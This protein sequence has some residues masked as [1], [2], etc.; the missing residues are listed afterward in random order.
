MHTL[1]LTL[2]IAPSSGSL[3]SLPGAAGG[4]AWVTDGG[5][6]VVVVVFWKHTQHTVAM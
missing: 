4:F 3:S 1:V 5:G 6:R 2:I